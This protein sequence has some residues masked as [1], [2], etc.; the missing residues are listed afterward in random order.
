M[1]CRPPFG[2][3][4][5]ASPNGGR[6]IVHAICAARYLRIIGRAEGG[7]RDGVV[8]VRYIKENIAVGPD[9]GAPCEVVL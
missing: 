9:Q 3:R 8:V 1:Y 6:Y 4:S 5:A 2:D 7:I